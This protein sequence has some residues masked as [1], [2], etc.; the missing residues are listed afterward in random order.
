MRIIVFLF[1]LFVSGVGVYASSASEAISRD[2]VVHLNVE[3]VSFTGAKKVLP[4]NVLDT[5]KDDV[6]E[7][8]Q[9]LGVAG[10]E[11]PTYT[12]SCYAPRDIRGGGFISLHA[13]AAAIDINYLM[14]PHYDVATHVI[15]PGRCADRQEDKGSIVAGLKSIGI[16]ENEIEAILETVIQ[17]EGSDDWFLNRGIERKGMVTP[18]VVE[19]FKMHG[20]NIWG[21]NWRQPMDYMH[22]Q[23]PRSLAEQLAIDDTKKPSGSR[24]NKAIWEEH[25][26]RVLSGT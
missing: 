25:K 10:V 9:N 14:N 15:I 20:F 4:L 17:P 21:G 7:I 24:T 6:V 12:V 23:L 5:I 22:F 11:F 19:I 18:K 26:A 13:Y 1:T 16:S 3:C 2:R 8:F